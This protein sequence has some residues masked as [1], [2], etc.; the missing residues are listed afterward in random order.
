MKPEGSLSYSQQL[1]AGPILNHIN[2]VHSFLRYFFTIHI[3]IFPYKSSSSKWSVPFKFSYKNFVCISHMR[4]TC[5]THLI[6]LDLITLI[7][8]DEY[9]KLWSSS[10]CKF[11]HTPVISSPLGPDIL[12]GTLFSHTRNLCSFLNVRDPCKAAGKIIL[13]YVLN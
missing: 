10:L 4:A 6:L 12:L 7:I 9:Y 2:T 3:D 8:Y 13:L 5:T 1:A 11:I